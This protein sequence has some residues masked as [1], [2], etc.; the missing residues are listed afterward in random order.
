MDKPELGNNIL[1]LG[2]VLDQVD[3]V[4]PLDLQIKSVII[5]VA[6]LPQSCAGCRSYE[7]ENG[8]IY[9]MLYLYTKIIKHTFLEKS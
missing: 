6:R 7:V 5:H 1:C 3:G 2:I 4:R 8:S 9:K